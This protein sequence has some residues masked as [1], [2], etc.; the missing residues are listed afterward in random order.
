MEILSEARKGYVHVYTGDGKGKTTA[1]LGL[2]L[3]AVGAGYRVL[4][5]QFIKGMAYSEIKALGAL[6]EQVEV[7]QY[8]RS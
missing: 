2:V 7:K 5:V 6:G 3:R 1:A 8:G 4:V